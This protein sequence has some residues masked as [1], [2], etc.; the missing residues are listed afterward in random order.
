M[1]NEDASDR[2]KSDIFF[3]N[4]CGRQAVLL[5]SDTDDS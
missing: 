2:T 1:K 3:G 4:R 5:A